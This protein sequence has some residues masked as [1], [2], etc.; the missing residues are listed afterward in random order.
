MHCREGS[1]ASAQHSCEDYPEFPARN[2]VVKIRTLVN[3]SCFV[4]QEPQVKLGGGDMTSAPIIER[5]GWGATMMS[6]RGA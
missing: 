2:E 4:M 3:H 5:T 6:M 1:K